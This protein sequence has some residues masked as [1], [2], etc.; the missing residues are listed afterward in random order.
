METGYI[1]SSSL[2]NL[3]GTLGFIG[4]PADSQ[5]ESSP[6]SQ[7]QEHLENAR[8]LW[9]IIEDDLSNGRQLY[10]SLLGY[11]R[12]QMRNYNAGE[13]VVSQFYLNL[14]EKHEKATLSFKY[15][16]DRERGFQGNPEIRPWV[17]ACVNNLCIDYRRKRNSKINRLIAKDYDLTE[18]LEPDLKEDIERDILQNETREIVNHAV[19]SLED[20]YKDLIRLCY[21]QGLKYREAA[22]LLGIPEGTV[23]SR[24]AGAKKSLREKL[25]KYNSEN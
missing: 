20:P 5:R 25:G 6:P 3:E 14:L 4:T 23:K 8:V 13:D 24:L 7:N 16:L 1:I 10:K 15:P 17:F 22:E 9:E 2:F 21:F 12:K 19:E 11:A 18:G